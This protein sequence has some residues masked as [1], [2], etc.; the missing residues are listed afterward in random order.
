M[1]KRQAE[2]SREDKD[3]PFGGF[4]VK[5]IHDQLRQRGHIAYAVPAPLPNKMLDSLEG[6][7]DNIAA[8]TA[9]AVAKRGPLSKLPASLAISIDTM[10][11]QKK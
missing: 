6:Y 2:A 8:A 7:L 5:N 4:T 10:V 11:E 1:A 9:Q 3:K